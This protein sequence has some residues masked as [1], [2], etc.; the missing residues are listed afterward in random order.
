M[1]R[2][3]KQMSEP[4]FDIFSGELDKNALWIETVEG[5]SNARERMEKMASEK[6]G[7]YFI[8]SASSHAVLA[9]TETFANPEGTS[10]RKGHVA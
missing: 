6:P 4:K 9:Q 2:G 3:R 1:V 8:F 5:L 10:R 7:R